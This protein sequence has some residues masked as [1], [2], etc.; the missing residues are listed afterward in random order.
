MKRNL[1]TL[2]RSCIYFS[3]ITPSLCLR[4][5]LICHWMRK[6]MSTH[7]LILSSL[8]PP[9]NPQSYLTY[10]HLKSTRVARKKMEIIFLDCIMYIQM[11]AQLYVNSLNSMNLFLDVSCDFRPL[12]QCVAWYRDGCWR[13][14]MDI[15]KLDVFTRS[16][17]L[18]PCREHIGIAILCKTP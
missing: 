11:F 1:G 12:S 7:C 9:S 13:G 18:D 6:R 4:Y 5:K 16:Q 15:H 10:V 3:T 17:R 8:L 2:L 14:R